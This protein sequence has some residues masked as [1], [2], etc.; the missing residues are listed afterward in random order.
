MQLLKLF[1]VV[2]EDAAPEKRRL[3]KL[4]DEPSISTPSKPNEQKTIKRD[5]VEDS[6]TEIEEVTKKRRDDVEQS[7]TEIGEEKEAEDV[8]PEKRRL[9]KLSDEP[10]LSTPSK[11]KEQ[12]TIKRD[13]VEDSDTEIEEV[14]KKRR[15]VL[16][17][18][19]TEKDK[20]IKSKAGGSSKKK[21]K[22]NYNKKLANYINHFHNFPQIYTQIL[23]TH[24]PIPLSSETHI[25]YPYSYLMEFSQ[26]QI[27]KY[28]HLP[29]VQAA[30]ELKAKNGGPT[31]DDYTEV[32]ITR[33]KEERRRVQENPNYKLA[34]STKKL[35]RQNF[36][37]IYKRKK[38]LNL[39]P[40]TTFEA[41][42]LESITKEE[43]AQY[44][45]LPIPEAASKL[46]VGLTVLKKCCRDMGFKRWPYRT[47]NSLDLLIN[48]LQAENGGATIDE[49]TKEII[50]SLKEGRM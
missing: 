23:F 38:E 29:V 37:A 47:L 43:I 21:L 42:P 30:K 14:T 40:A 1:M 49:C 18:S 7:D 8:A 25:Y 28:F 16:E 45:H 32:I 34:P 19:D 15:V 22:K 6:D 2:A 50:T 31:V 41:R 13:D 36:K 3:K 4:S 9:K 26:E 17:D 20:Q 44:F 39:D 11:P 46:N 12:K 24:L 10:S 5:D 27:A 35:R 48:T 33:L